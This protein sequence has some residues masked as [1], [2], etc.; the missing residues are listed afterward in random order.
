MKIKTVILAGGE[1]TRLSVLTAKRAKPAVPFAGR[2]RIIDFALSNCVNSNL[3]DIMIIAQYRPHSL[4]RHIGGGGPWDLSREFSGGISIFSPF[5]SLSADWFSGTA[6]AI[7]QNFSFIK[8]DI[9]DLVLIL[10]GDHIYNMDYSRMI[11]NHVEKQAEVSLATIH[12]DPADAHRF[13][14]VD[15]D[16]EDRVVSFL[17]KPEKPPSNYANMGIY[18]FNF[19]LLDKILWEDHLQEDSQHDFGRNILP[20][21]VNDGTRIFAYPYDGYWVDVGTINTYWQAHMDLLDVSPKINL[22]DRSWIIHTRSEER[23]PAHVKAGAYIENSLI[24]DGCQIESGARVINSVLSPGVK[25]K[26]DVDIIESIILT[27]TEIGSGSKVYRGILDKRSCVGKNVLIGD[28]EN[29]EIL[30][31]MIGMNSI[32]PDNT[33]LEPGAIVGTD[34]IPT[35]FTKNQVK[36]REYIQTRRLPN[37]I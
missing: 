29:S 12:V 9:P 18:L 37:E 26:S 28:P 4:I 36:T 24:C 7:Q 32:I 22:H 31:S 8:R 2:Y 27:D 3:F 25:I 21:L 14:I 1:G 11:R 5:R 19:D 6:D 33:V 17:E 16:Q 34:V 15:T 30:I 35:D 20:R 10:S 23:S 13:G